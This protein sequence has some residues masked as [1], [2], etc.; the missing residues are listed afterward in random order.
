MPSHTRVGSNQSIRILPL[1][2]VQV[3]RLEEDE[4]HGGEESSQ[5]SVEDD[6]KD[7]DFRCRKKSQIITEL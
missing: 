2:L 1:G 3:E 5:E 6:I 7:Q 4:Q